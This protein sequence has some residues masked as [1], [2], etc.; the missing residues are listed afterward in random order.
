M[1]YKLILSL[2]LIGHFCGDFYFQSDSMAKKKDDK[3]WLMIAH[4]FIYL[5][6]I[7]PPV[8]LILYVPVKGWII[9]AAVPAMHMVVDLIKALFNRTPAF[10]KH[11]A[12]WF[13]TDQ[14]IHISIITAVAWLCASYGGVAYSQLGAYLRQLYEGLQLGLPFAKM[15]RLVGL[16]MFLGKPVNVIIRKMC[17]AGTDGQSDHE[18]DQKT[19][20]IIGGLER[21]LTALFIVLHQYAA[22][23]FAFTAKSVTRLNKIS[24]DPEFAETYLIGTFS[25]LIFAIASV[26]LFLNIP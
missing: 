23:G 15:I 26:V 6:A 13:I 7:L 17:G 10:Q 11:T 14:I 9:L 3:W 22:V 25:S 8:L 4:G 24:N 21:Y 5:I 20:R 1:D 16:I 12:F 18:E 2:L 19:G